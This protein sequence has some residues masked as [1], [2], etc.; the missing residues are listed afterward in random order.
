MAFHQLQPVAA[1]VYDQ[2][3]SRLHQPLLQVGQQSV[4]D[5]PGQRQSPPE[6]SQ[7]IG[8]PIQ[9]PVHLEA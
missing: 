7:F 5:L 2:P 6:I 3:P 9:N 4:A 1:G 8:N